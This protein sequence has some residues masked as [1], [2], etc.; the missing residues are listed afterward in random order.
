MKFTVASVALLAVTAS[1][2]NVKRQESGDKVLTIDIG[3]KIDNLASDVHDLT[4]KIASIATGGVDPA[5]SKVNELISDV[6]SKA[7][8]VASDVRDV[9]DKITSV[10]ASKASKI[11][12]FVGAAIADGITLSIP[13]LPTA[14]VNTEALNNYISEIQSKFDPT[15]ISQIKAGQTPAV[16]T[17]FIDSLPTEYKTVAA[18]AFSDAAKQTDTPS[19]NGGSTAGS[20]DKGSAAAGRSLTGLMAAVCVGV[21]GLAIYL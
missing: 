5:S 17:S 6:A 1:A 21:A 15:V 19:N 10:A 3:S 9:G 4:S 7:T 2:T 14:S 20:E 8:S 16:V 11:T 13:D 18:V 12:S